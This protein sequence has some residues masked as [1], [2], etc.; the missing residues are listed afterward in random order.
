MEKNGFVYIWKNLTNGKKYIGYHIGDLDDGYISSSHNELFW[1]DYYNKDMSWEREIVFTGDSTA[2]LVK[3]Q[4]MLENVDINSAEYY[5]NAR[6]AKIIFTE[7]VKEKM[8]K[9]SKKRWEL[10]NEHDKNT[11]NKKI[12]QSKKGIPRN[13]KTIE[14]LKNYYKSDDFI[15]IIK[16]ENYDNIR[17][18]ITESNRGKKRSEKFRKEQSNRFLGEK[19]PMFGKSHSEEF[20]IKKREYMLKKNPGKNKSE[21]T[22]KRISDAKKGISS[23]MKGVP[24]KKVT[25]PHCGKIG[26]EG[27]MHR[28]HFNN[29]K[30]KN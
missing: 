1:N 27:L 5:N 9:S 24:R 30:Y 11:R 20:K 7:E 8:R 12:S 16:R 4:E 17:K 19:N 2:C 14:K 28:W 25:C 6:G 21:I 23:K 15:G 22:K 10:M 26:G 18:R 13:K 3:E 29:C